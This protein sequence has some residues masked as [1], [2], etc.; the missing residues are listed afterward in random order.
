VKDKRNRR[1]SIKGHRYPMP[2]LSKE[3]RIGEGRLG[4]S[5][6]GSDVVSSQ[7]ICRFVLCVCLLMC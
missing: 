7:Q 3:T 5:P 1:V 2:Y 6:E 4:I